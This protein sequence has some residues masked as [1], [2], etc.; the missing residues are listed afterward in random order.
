MALESIYEVE[1]QDGS[2]RVARNDFERRSSFLGAAEPSNDQMVFQAGEHEDVIA[3]NS[4]WAT[5]DWNGDGEFDS[6]DLIVAFQDAGFEAGPRAAA[7]TVPEPSSILLLCV[8]ILGTI[9]L[10]RTS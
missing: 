5:G 3:G 6:G 9:G 7:A 8:G 1:F 10:K 4:T 2:Y